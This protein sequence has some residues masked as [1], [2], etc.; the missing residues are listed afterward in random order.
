MSVQTDAEDDATY[1]EVQVAGA[2]TASS[3]VPML[4]ANVTCLLPGL[5]ITTFAVENPYAMPVSVR[6]GAPTQPWLV[7]SES[8]RAGFVVEPGTT[9]Q[10]LVVADS[11]LYDNVNDLAEW[12]VVVDAQGQAQVSVVERREPRYPCL[13]TLARLH[14]GF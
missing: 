4:T 11:S 14:P 2:A 7:V 1:R 6:V 8:D 5:A 12:V 9:K 13:P 10:M 3:G